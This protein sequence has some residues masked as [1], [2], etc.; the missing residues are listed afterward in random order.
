MKKIAKKKKDPSRWERI[1][2]VLE[3]GGT[4]QALPGRV[5]EF[6]WI[7][8]TITGLLESSLGGCLCK[9]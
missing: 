4:V 5:D 3:S 1:K 6:D 9:P 7:K 2:T 8:R